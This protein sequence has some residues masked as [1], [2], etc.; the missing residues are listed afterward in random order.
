MT[1]HGPDGEGGASERFE[2]FML[3]LTRS[4]LEPDRVAGLI[5][6]LGS[7]EKRSFDTG[8][9]LVRLVGGGFALDLNMQPT[10]GYRNASQTQMT[11][12][13]EAVGIP[14]DHEP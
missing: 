11:S 8:E 3:R 1:A 7:G 10:T 6:R 4:A 13:P 5:E 14:L 9:Q 12:S 2:Y